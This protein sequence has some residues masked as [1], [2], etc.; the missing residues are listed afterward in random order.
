[1]SFIRFMPLMLCFLLSSLALAW[2]LVVISPQIYRPLMLLIGVWA[3][4]GVKKTP[5]RYGRAIDALWFVAA[6]AGL[7]WPLANGDPFL[8]REFI[9]TSRAEFSVA[10]NGYVRS[11]S[12]WISDRTACYLASGKP[13]LVQSTGFEKRLPT[14]KGLLTFRTLQEAIEGVRE[15]NANYLEHA[16]AARAIAEQHFSTAVVLPRLMQRVG[17]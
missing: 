16:H 8:Y 17:L 11:N 13:V 6:L 14:G 12:G 10:K 2:V 9:Q 7:G 5:G 4:L 15:I 1:M 3:T